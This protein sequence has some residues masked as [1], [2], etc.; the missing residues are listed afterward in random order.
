VSRWLLL[1]G[2]FPPDPGGVA[3]YTRA[4]A[5]GLAARGHEVHVAAPRSARGQPPQG[6]A[7]LHP[8]PDCFG[9][10]SLPRLSSLTRELRPER[11]FV[12]YVPHAYGYKALNFGFCAWLLAQ[13]RRERVWTQFHEVAFPFQSPPWRRTNLL[14]AGHQA[15]A[16]LV[17]RAS[18][19]RF[20]TTRRW[21]RLLTRWDP[22]PPAWLPVPSNVATEVDPGEAAAWRERLGLGPEVPLLGHFGNYGRLLGPLV[23][24][25]LPRVL[26]RSPRAHAL[27][28]GR[29]GPEFRDSLRADQAWLARRVHAPG[30]LSAREV[31]AAIGACDL[32]L[33]PYE[34]GVTSRRGS[35]MASLALGACVLTTWEPTTAPSWSEGRAVALTSFA[36]APLATHAVELLADPEQ[37]AA[38]GTRARELY[39]GSFAL[40]RTLDRLE[41]AL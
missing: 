14:A 12:Q 1:S 23:R 36:P 2:E 4:V 38:L 21:E 31:A 6:Q 35:L 8:L 34:D 25:T 3:D 28:L 15:M 11:L 30:P 39:Q 9:P 24:E 40:E 26:E 27:L 10:R 37:R 22:T 20:V 7:Q 18:E 17:S 33:Q 32:M 29:S 13:S 5:E 41:E 16:A 19:R